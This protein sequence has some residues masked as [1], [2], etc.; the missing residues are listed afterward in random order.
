MGVNERPTCITVIGWTWIIVGGLLCYSAAM[1]LWVRQLWE[2]PPELRQN[3]SVLAKLSPLLALAQ[4]IV[5]ILGVVSGISFLKLRK[6][7]RK[8]LQVLGTLCLLLV[9]GFAV[10]GMVMWVQERSALGP[11]GY[12]LM[13]AVKGVVDTA[14]AAVPL[15]IMLGYLGGDRVRKAMGLPPVEV[16]LADADTPTG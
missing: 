3:L 13:L 15:M 2:V 10:Y 12:A 11:P 4:I 6:W 7:A 9:L 1:S 14:L 5:G 8:V 16:A